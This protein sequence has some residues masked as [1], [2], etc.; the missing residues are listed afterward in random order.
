MIACATPQPLCK[1]LIFSIR[2]LL[3]KTET[4]E[5]LLIPS[6]DAVRLT[7]TNLR[8]PDSGDVVDAVMNAP[9]I[10]QYIGDY[11]CVQNNLELES[12]SEDSSLSDGDRT[13]V[14]DVSPIL[15]TSNSPADEQLYAIHSEISPNFSIY[16]F[17]FNL[18]ICAL[19]FQP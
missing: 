19:K 5:K 13:L 9:P 7:T 2:F 3:C 14:G 11:K 10:V 4:L 6:F 17:R 8:Q 15:S 1:F 12:N 16:A 18:D